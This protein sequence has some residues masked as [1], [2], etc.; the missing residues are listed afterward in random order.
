M[1][2]L[3]CYLMLIA[4]YT[5][6]GKHDATLYPGTNY[7]NRFIN[8]P[9]ISTQPEA[10]PMKPFEIYMSPRFTSPGVAGPYLQA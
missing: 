7:G 1:N 10:C 9:R 5:I 6:L 2:L 3:H 8:L 4:Q